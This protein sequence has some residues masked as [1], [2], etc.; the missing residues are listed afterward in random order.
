VCVCVRV[1]V[2][3]C[4]CLFGGRGAAVGHCQLVAQHTQAH[5]EAA[6]GGGGAPPPPPPAP[7]PARGGGPSPPPPHTHKHTTTAALHLQPTHLTFT[8][9]PP[10]ASLPYGSPSAT[11]CT[12]K[13]LS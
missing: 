6:V 11:W 3:A 7:P 8:V 2:C 5:R 13:P 10:L 1:C 4:V 9:L 12:S